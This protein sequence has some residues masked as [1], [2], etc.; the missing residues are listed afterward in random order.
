MHSF[1]QRFIILGNSRRV[2]IVHDRQTAHA[3]RHFILRSYAKQSRHL[4]QSNKC[5][6]QRV[7][8]LRW[9]H[10]W[11]TGGFLGRFLLWQHSFKMIQTILSCR[12]RFNYRQ[13][14]GSTGRI[15]SPGRQRQQHEYSWH[16]E[17]WAQLETTFIEGERKKLRGGKI[18]WAFYFGARSFFFLRS[19]W[20]EIASAISGH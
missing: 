17:F 12:T 7:A 8:R 5:I 13:W 18:N 11:E 2:L 16:H 3:Q 9:N 10:H 19:P 14:W 6:S 1:L 4:T 20:S 15:G